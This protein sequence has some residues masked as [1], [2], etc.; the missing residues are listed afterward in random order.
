[1]KPASLLL[2]ATIMTFL[3]NTLFA[4]ETAQ[5]LVKDTTVAIITGLKADQAA[6]KK[7]PK[8]AVALVEKIVL[9]QFNFTVMSEKT[10]KKDWPKMS[11]SQ[12]KQFETEFKTL[13]VRTY[14]AA[15]ADNFDQEITYLPWKSKKD[16]TIVLVRTEVAQSAGFPIPLNYKLVKQKDGSWKVTDVIIDGISLIK[17]YK[18]SFSKEIIASGVDKLIARL[19]ESNK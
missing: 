6:I 7:D 14:S 4:D 2:I 1:M 11:A 16:G 15:L 5:K 19:V 9:P 3:S 18:I 12:K 8:L 17:N 13:L 10:L